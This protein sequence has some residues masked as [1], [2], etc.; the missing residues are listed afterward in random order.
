MANINFTKEEDELIALIEDAVIAGKNKM[1]IIDNLDD[2]FADVKA[3]RFDYLYSI[4]KCR[5]MYKNSSEYCYKKNSKSFADHNKSKKEVAI[6][7]NHQGKSIPE[8]AKELEVEVHTVEYYLGCKKEVKKAKAVSRK[9]KVLELTKQGMDKNDIAKKLDI[10]EHTVNCYITMLRKEGKLPAYVRNKKMPEGCPQDNYSDEIIPFD[11]LI[12][13][14]TSDFKAD[15]IKADKSIV[16]HAKCVQEVGK[17]E[18]INN[19]KPVDVKAFKERVNPE[20][21]IEQEIYSPISNYMKIATDIASLVEKKNVDYGNSFDKSI[22]EWGDV[23][24]FIRV[25]DKFNRAKNL[26]KNEAQVKY[27]KLED[28]LKDIIGYTLLYLNYLSQKEVFI[29]EKE[30]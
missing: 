6:E 26:S 30:N 18:N 1:D 22:D 29:C 9:Q 28:T 27:E 24:Y 19:I 4:A 23:A 13:P 17:V 20:N 8:I 3:T 2:K 16:K 12:K 10:K 14:A 15:E 11:E 21:E 5:A 7:L 25:N